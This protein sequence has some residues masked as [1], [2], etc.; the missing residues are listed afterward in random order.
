MSNN[1]T[2][3]IDLLKEVNLKVS[4]ILGEIMKS[5]KDIYVTKDA[6]IYLYEIGLDSKNIA[7]VLGIT[8][9]RASQEISRFKKAKKG[10]ENAGK[11]NTK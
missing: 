4:L 6:I 8:S 5:K 3:I 7:Q 1:E 11:K 2:E 9:E 10:E